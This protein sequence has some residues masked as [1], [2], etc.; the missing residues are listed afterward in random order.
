MKSVNIATFKA[1]M[2]KY[3]GYIRQGEEVIVLDRNHPLAR[4]L[5][6]KHAGQK[7]EI[8]APLEH[9]KNLVEFHFDP[10]Q[11]VNTDSLAFLLEE[12]G[13]R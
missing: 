4:V 2:G 13:S 9:S 10:I 1:E 12:R 7:I 6:F 5:P 3:L 8:E 11:T